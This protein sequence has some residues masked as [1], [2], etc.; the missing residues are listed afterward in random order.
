LISNPLIKTVTK[1]TRG[2][3]RK[4][5]QASKAFGAGRLTRKEGHDT[6]FAACVRAELTGT[7]CDELEME[8]ALASPAP[9]HCADAR[10]RP[11]GRKMKDGLEAKKEKI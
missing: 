4:I 6:A 2:C 10:K 3:E 11:A 5:M 9:L 7:L 8:M 1:L